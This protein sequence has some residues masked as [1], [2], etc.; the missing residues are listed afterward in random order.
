MKE[1]VKS[2]MC[3]FEALLINYFGA[4]VTTD[5]ATKCSRHFYLFLSIIRFVGSAHSY[6]FGHIILL[7]PFM[8]QMCMLSGYSAEASEKR[9]E[10][11]RK[12]WTETTIHVNNARKNIYKHR[13]FLTDYVLFGPFDSLNL[14]LSLVPLSY[15]SSKHQIVI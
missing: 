8:I 6:V 10:E 9:T 1:F 15:F 2:P 11:Q 5:R 7:P 3:S 13:S 14:S 12:K 4:Y